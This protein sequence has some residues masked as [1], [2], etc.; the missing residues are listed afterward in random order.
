MNRHVVAIYGNI[1]TDYRL[2]RYYG[3]GY[4]PN[5][6]KLSK[7]VHTWLSIGIYNIGWLKLIHRLLDW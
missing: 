4:K 5:V 7:H 3:L 6:D 2:R 1:A